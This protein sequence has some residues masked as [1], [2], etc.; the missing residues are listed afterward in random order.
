MKKLWNR[1][2]VSA[3]LMTV[4]AVVLSLPVGPRQVTVVDAVG[5]CPAHIEIHGSTTVDPMT[6]GSVVPFTAAWPTTSM[7]ALS[8]GSGNGIQDLNSDVNGI[9]P[10][11]L[12]ASHAD[13]ATSS[14]PL[15]GGTGGPEP[16]NELLH[17]YAWKIALDAFVIGVNGSSGNMNF[18]AGGMQKAHLTQIYNAQG[19]ITSLHWD[20]L[21]PAIPG[22]PHRLIVP[23]MRITGSGS[24]PDFNSS[25]GV[26]NANEDLTYQALGG[27]GGSFPRQVE[28]LG[29]ADAVNGV[30]DDQIS[31]TSLSQ[32]STHPNMLIVPISGAPSGGPYIVPS[33]TT[34]DNGTYP[35]GRRLFEATH[36]KATVS[37]VDNTTQVR[38]D[39]WINFM[40]SPAGDALIAADGYPTIP[41]AAVPPIP[42]WDIN[43]DGVVSLGDLGAVVGRWG[44]SSGCAGW[45]RPDANNDGK[46]SLGDIGVAI[47]HWGQDGLIC[48]TAHLCVRDTTQGPQ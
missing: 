19:G 14:R 24:R 3:A 17:N 22:A 46:A 36:D 44:A 27:D 26:S 8:I 31:Y 42:D 45:I 34:V 48:D 47:A 6:Q 18:L 23:R 38:A 16:G 30:N 4:A 2:A 12:G 43:L 41:P 11:A 28:S 21:V 32:V 13:I 7:T 40:R 1:I 25:I 35:L 10:S 37:R 5:A 20:Q 29:M 9:G 15:N 33:G 39:D